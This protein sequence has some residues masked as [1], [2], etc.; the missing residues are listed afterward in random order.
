MLPAPFAVDPVTGNLVRPDLLQAR[1]GLSL[2][3]AAELRSKLLQD[4]IGV[5]ARIGQ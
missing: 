5:G 2:G 4:A 1:I 3:Q